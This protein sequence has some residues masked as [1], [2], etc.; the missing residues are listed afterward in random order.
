MVPSGAACGS[1]GREPSVGATHS[2]MLTFRSPGTTTVFGR[3]ARSGKVLPRYAAM[4]FALSSGSFTIESNVSRQSFSLKPHD[5]VMLFRPWHFVHSCATTS[6]PGPSG[7]SATPPFLWPAAGAIVHMKMAAAASIPSE[8]FDMS[9]PQEDHL[10]E[11]VTFCCRGSYR[12]PASRWNTP[13][14]PA[15]IYTF[16]LFQEEI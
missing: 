9:P 14:T 16:P 1:C 7:R 10:A 8:I 2:R 5:W 12:K 11:G 15:F 13:A 3:S 4:T 6:L